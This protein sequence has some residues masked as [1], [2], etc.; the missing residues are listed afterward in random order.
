MPILYCQ[1]SLHHMP[2]VSCFKMPLIS[3]S[4]SSVLPPLYLSWAW[5]ITS[6]QLKE[7]LPFPMHPAHFCQIHHSY[8]MFPPLLF[9]TYDFR[10]KSYG[11]GF[12]APHNMH[13]QS[14]VSWRCEGGGAIFSGFLLH[15][16][17]VLFLHTSCQL[18]PTYNQALLSS[19]ST[20][21]IKPLLL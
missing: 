7:T 1:R 16:K 12:N 19:Y 8:R 9:I 20:F 11:T 14:Q 4:C 10:Y 3:V 18:P 15:A 5:P 2:F 21:S 13:S 17:L 6:I